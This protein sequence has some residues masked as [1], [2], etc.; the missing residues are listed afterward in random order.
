MPSPLA[1]FHPAVAKWFLTDL[2]PP[3]P[4]QAE[5]WPAI[6]QGTH[7]LVA[8]PTGSG[9]T[10]AAFLAALDDLVH[11]S[12]ASADGL[13]DE[14]RVVYVSPLK[15]LSNDIHRNLELPLAG[16]E[17]E[18]AAMGLPAPGIR[19]AVR[20]GDTPSSARSKMVKR[21][22]HVLVTTPESLYI[23]LGSAGGRAHARHRPLGD[24]RRDPRRGGQQARL[25]SGAHPGATRRAGGAPRP[26]AHPHRPVGDPEADRRGG[27]LPGRHQGGERRRG[28]ERRPC[29]RARGKGRRGRAARPAARSSTSATAA[30]ST[31]RSRSPARRSKR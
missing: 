19:R 23:L 4:A 30:P 8:A 29:E 27:A 11:E 9:K 18:L 6:R 10:L 13:P 25:A 21:P 28:G 17:R 16:I 20:T 5:A 22:P 26:A 3:T 12:L 1:D 7:T 31:W 15:A 24:R 2:G 14:T